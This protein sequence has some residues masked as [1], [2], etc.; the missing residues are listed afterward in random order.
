MSPPLHA[1][2]NFE[3]NNHTLYQINEHHGPNGLKQTSKNQ[4]A[5][6]VSRWS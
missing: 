6:Q 5:M 3:S 4:Q 2:V 1:S